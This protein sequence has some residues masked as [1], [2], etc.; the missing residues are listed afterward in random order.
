MVRG[1][2]GV[3]IFAIIQSSLSLEIWSTFPGGG[4]GGGE[5]GGGK[6]KG[7]NSEIATPDGYNEVLLTTGGKEI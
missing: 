4:G 6:L 3:L 2:F 1:F 7:G 5:G